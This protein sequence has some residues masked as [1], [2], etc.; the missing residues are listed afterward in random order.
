MEERS[1]L[2]LGVGNLLLGDEG[3]GV[4]VAQQLAEES[5]PEFMEVVDGGTGGFHLIPVMES[6][7]YVVLIDAT[8]DGRQPG[9]VTLLKPRFAS[10]YPP[11]LSAH[12]V[13]LKDL[14]SSLYLIGKVPEV[15]LITVS[16][17]GVQPM[18]L[19]LS[20]PV[21]EAIPEVKKKIS[22]ILKELE[23]AAIT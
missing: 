16:I 3:V 19:E 20:E 12:D 9:T 5:L 1:I 15:Y 13:G 8:I 6:F 14:I 4:H 10:D 7:P 22:R 21:K 17:T 18:T 2:V 11:S 23:L